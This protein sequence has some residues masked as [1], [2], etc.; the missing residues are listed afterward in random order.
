[1]SAVGVGFLG[2][3]PVTQAI[4]L[5]ALASM[6]EE[7]RILWVMDANSAVANVVAGRCGATGTTEVASVL[8]D[9]AVDVVAVCSPNAFHAGQVIAACRAGKKVVLCEKPLAI[10]MEEAVAIKSAA[11]ASGTAI[12]V[13]TMHAYDPAYRAALKAW[14]STGE[15]ALRIRSGIFIPSNDEFINQITEQVPVVPVPR[16]DATLDVAFKKMM[17]RGA[18]LGLAIHNVPLIRDFQP[19]MGQL[20]SAE[21]MPPYGYTLLTEDST[22]TVELTALAPGKWPPK[23]HFDVVGATYRLKASMPPSYVMAGSGRVEL[24]G[25]DS[26]QV[27][28]FDHNGYQAV[29]QAV[30]R[31]VRDG[32]APPIP[33]ETAVADLAF[34]LDLAGSI[35][36]YLEARA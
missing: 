8:A 3:G 26:T 34:A 31:T 23:W 1:M 2:A 5:G 30:F 22:S 15:A 32:T 24:E 10:S 29:W 25:P 16:G 20:L 27:F 12:F 17:L 11:E 14:K 13:N 9:P 28:S 21:F 7:F 19:N 6:P 18:M 35:D 4:H 33:L 36:H